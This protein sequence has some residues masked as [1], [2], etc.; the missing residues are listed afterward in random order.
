MLGVLHGRLRS[1]LAA[2]RTLLNLL[3]APLRHCDAHEPLR[4]P[5]GGRRRRHLRHAEDDARTAR[6]SRST[7]CAAGGTLHRIGLHDAALYKDNHLA[8]LTDDVLAARLADAVRRV[9]EAGPVRFVEV[10]VDHLGQLDAVLAMAPGLVDIILLDNMSL[11]DMR[12][13]VRRRDE[14]GTRPQLEASGGVSLDRVREIA[15]CG[16]DRISVGGLTHSVTVLDIG[17]DIKPVA[18]KRSK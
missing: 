9:R 10:E 16:V 11:D 12:E 5:G 1:I 14:H 13:A 2:E 8:G 15:D 4:R 18:V 17:L 6:G 7:P 3:F